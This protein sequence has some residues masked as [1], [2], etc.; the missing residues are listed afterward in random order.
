MA[1]SS[2]TNLVDGKPAAPA[3]ERTNGETAVGGA[4]AVV[5]ALAQPAATKPSTLPTFSLQDRVV[6]ITGGASGLGLV[7]GKGVV[8][9][10]AHL[11]IVDINSWFDPFDRRWEESSY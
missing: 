2:T 9:S 5:E 3:L 6:A 11:A 4:E 1:P 7:M 10:G 8:D